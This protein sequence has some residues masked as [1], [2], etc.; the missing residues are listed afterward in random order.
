MYA[1]AAIALSDFGE[2]A[3]I[4]TRE[5]GKVLWESHVDLAGAP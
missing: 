2:R 1:A 4:L 3:R 5:Q